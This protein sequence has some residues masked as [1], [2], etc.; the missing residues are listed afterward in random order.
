L[1][2]GDGIQ[3]G[4]GMSCGDGGRYCKRGQGAATGNA[5]PRRPRA[6]RDIRRWGAGGC[7]QVRWKRPVVGVRSGNSKWLEPIKKRGWPMLLGWIHFKCLSPVKKTG[8]LMFIIWIHFKCL[9]PFEK[10]VYLC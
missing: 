2:R 5:R 7:L 6:N 3:E 8:G 9:S 4:N 10:P 1:G